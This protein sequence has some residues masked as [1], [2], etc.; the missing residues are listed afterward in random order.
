MKLLSAV[1]RK[2][3]ADRPLIHIIPHNEDRPHGHAGVH[4]IKKAPDLKTRGARIQS[5]IL[6]FSHPDCNC[7]YRNS[8]GMPSVI[9]LQT[10]S[11]PGQSRVTD[12]FT[13]LVVADFTA[14]GNFHPA[15][16]NSCSFFVKS[17]KLN[18]TQPIIYCFCRLSIHFP[19]FFREITSSNSGRKFSRVCPVRSAALLLHSGCALC[20]LIQT[21]AILRDISQSSI[22]HQLKIRNF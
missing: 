16:K 9:L 15:P 8:H 13:K 17:A 11:R 22:P 4:R 1:R 19:C 10:R 12:S 3:G 14:G 6:F 7:R 18:F 21:F 2:T 5:R 20:H